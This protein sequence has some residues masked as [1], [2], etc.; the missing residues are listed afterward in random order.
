MGRK[1]VGEVASGRAGNPGGSVAGIGSPVFRVLLA[2]SEHVPEV[3]NVMHPDRPW[4]IF[5]ALPYSLFALFGPMA[6]AA[7]VFRLC[8]RLADRCF[9]KPRPH[10][11]P[12]D[13]KA[14]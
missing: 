9:L 3:P 1:A 12:P 4:I 8:S 6:A 14:V 7:W 11:E 10:M 2:D 13:A 5:V